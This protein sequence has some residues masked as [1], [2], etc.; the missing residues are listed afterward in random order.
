MQLQ[1]AF[2]F[3]ETEEQARAMC[4]QYRKTHPRRRK[5]AAHYTPWASTS[6]TDPA[7]FIVWFYV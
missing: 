5:H 4:E 1:P 6:P 2:K 3:T 7:R